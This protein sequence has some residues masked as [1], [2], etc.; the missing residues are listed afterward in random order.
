MTLLTFF[1]VP[2]SRFHHMPTTFAVAHLSKLNATIQELEQ[3]LASRADEANEAISKWE[4]HCTT[5]EETS[6]N[7]EEELQAVIEERDKLSL[8]SLSLEESMVRQLT[9][10]CASCQ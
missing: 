1:N 7:L 2:L 3:D 6:Q 5:L 4:S 8:L 10:T 9:V